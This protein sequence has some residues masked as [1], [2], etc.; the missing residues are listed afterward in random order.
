HLVDLRRD[1]HAVDEVVELHEAGHLSHDRVSMRIPGRADLARLDRVAFLHVDDR[2]VRDLVTL[3]LATEVI[4]HAD[5][6]RTRHRHEVPFLVLHRLN[7]VEADDA[8]V[9]N[10]D[11]AGGSGSRRRT[12]DVERT[13]CQLSARFTDG[14]R[15]DNAHRLTDAD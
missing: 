14:L 3:A 8:L 2:A 10:L 1:R 15:G 11:A 6:A 7:V 5:F 13:H 12:T 4:D 9:A